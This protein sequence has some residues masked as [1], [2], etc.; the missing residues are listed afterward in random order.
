MSAV[1]TKKAAPA[2]R[3]VKRPFVWS[4]HQHTE[5]GGLDQLTSQ[6]AGTVTLT[7]DIPATGFL[8]NLCI[9]LTTSTAGT[10]GTAGIDYPFNILQELT[11]SDVNGAP[12]FGPLD[13][14]SAYL[15]QLIGGYAFRQDPKL[16]PNYS[17][18]VTAPA[19]MLRIPLEINENDAFGAISNMNSSQNYRVRVILNP[20]ATTF[21]VNPS[22]VP[23]LRIRVWIESWTRPAPTSQ[24]GAP[25]EEAPPFH[26]VSQFWSKVNKP[27]VAGENYIPLPKVGNM[28]RAIGFVFRDASG[29]RTDAQAGG[30]T[31]LLELR[32]DQRVLIQSPFDLIKT[33]FAEAAILAGAPDVGFVPFLFND[34]V[35]GHIGNGSQ[36]LYLPTLQSTRLELRVPAGLVGSVDILT[37]DVARVAVDPNERYS[38]EGGTGFHAEG[39]ASPVQ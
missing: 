37:N 18:T 29:V 25:Q 17:A 11:L 20:L 4:A 39:S 34:D 24:S 30:A 32:M 2:A 12:I 35:L 38:F 28:I 15:A 6:A 14:Y 26:G 23:V 36:Q 10:G 8:R 19:F 3:V 31:G 33:Q 16:Q 9:M 1:D 13:G 27:T 7:G 5:Y 22:P 21:S